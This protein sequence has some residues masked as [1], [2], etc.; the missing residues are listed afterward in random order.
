MIKPW[1][2]RQPNSERLSGWFDTNC[3]FLF[4]GW[5]NTFQPCTVWR[6]VSLM[7]MTGSI[8]R[9]GYYFN[10]QTNM[11]QGNSNP[12]STENLEKKVV[13]P[14]PPQKARRLKYFLVTIGEMGICCAVIF[15]YFHFVVPYESTDDAFIVGYITLVSSR[16]FRVY[17]TTLPHCHVGCDEWLI[18][19]LCRGFVKTI[20]VRFESP[21]KKTEENL[22]DFSQVCWKPVTSCMRAG[23]N[24]LTALRFAANMQV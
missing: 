12:G 7:T 21:K 9:T 23:C 4:S 3:F 5:P 15:Y 18:F 6:I 22:G 19:S 14:P 24:P 2:A 16:V 8:S 11:E 20:T 13:E 10:R 17:K 1:T